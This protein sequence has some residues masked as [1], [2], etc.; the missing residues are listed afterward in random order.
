MPPVYILRAVDVGADSFVSCWKK[1]GPEIQ[2]EAR[3]FVSEMILCERMPAKLHFHKLDGYKDI[4]TIH[5]TSDDKYK[6]SFTIK[7]GVAVMRRI[8][9]HDWI[10]KNPK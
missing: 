9:L 2:R 3:K 1:L 7:D 8:G 4:W 10:D 6:A 5:V